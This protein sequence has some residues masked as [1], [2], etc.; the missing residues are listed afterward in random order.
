MLLVLLL[1]GCLQIR[2]AWLEDGTPPDP[3]EEPDDPTPGQPDPGDD[4]DVQVVVTLPEGSWDMITDAAGSSV[5][6]RIEV[7]YRP[8]AEGMAAM[9]A[10]SGTFELLAGEEPDVDLPPGDY[11]LESRGYGGSGDW[12]LAY[13]AGSASIS[14]DNAEMN[15]DL[16]P[17]VSG[18]S[19]VPLL[20][21]A[22]A[23][24]GEQHTFR[25]QLWAAAGEFTVT[26]TDPDVEFSSQAS[27]VEVDGLFATVVAPQQGLLDLAAVYTGPSLL[28][29]EIMPDGQH[30]ASTQLV[31]QTHQESAEDW[32]PPVLSF[33]ELDPSSG[34]LS[35]HAR[36]N[37]GLVA[38]RVY[39][40]DEL[41]GSN[42]LTD[43]APEQLFFD[44]SDP[45]R[46]SVAWEPTGSSE[47]LRAEAVD[48]SGNVS[49]AFRALN[50]SAPEDED[51]LGDYITIRDARE[52]TAVGFPADTGYCP[53]NEMTTPGQGLQAVGAGLQAVGAIGGLLLAPTDAMLPTMQNTWS[54]ADGLWFADSGSFRAN[55]VVVVIVDDFGNSGSHDL[56]A[57]LFGSDLSAEML[58]GIAESGLLSHGALVTHHMLQLFEARGYT[59]DYEYLDSNHS[60]PTKV[61][62]NPYEPSRMVIRLVNTHG[63]DTDGIAAALRQS[64]GG[65]LPASPALGAPRV[66]VNMSFVML[67]CAVTDDLAASGIN[68]FEEY[69]E[70]LAV[71]NSVGLDQVESLV[72]RQ[73]TDDDLLNYL[74]CPFRDPADPLV[75]CAATNSFADRLV[76]VASAGNFGSDY[77]LL[78]AAAPTVIAVSA[79]DQYES[80]F[81]GRSNYSNPG[82]VMAPGTNVELHS[83]GGMTVSYSGTSFAAPVVTV[84]TALDMRRHVPSCSDAASDAAGLAIPELADINVGGVSYE[85]VKLNTEF[86]GG[87]SAV[88]VSDFCSAP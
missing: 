55:D 68:S 29:G 13:G 48:L 62:S 2:D 35:G 71:V 87:V 45:E 57:G 46:W 61:L 10:G 19:L 50:V 34:M 20:P 11:E 84:M 24:P 86:A 5:L 63:L 82:S 53:A 58:R 37:R 42:V 25:L 21:T 51:D 1:P 40:G 31:V 65:S 17:L 56:P 66:V 15:L 47:I 70:A 88:V 38:L 72:T 73:P 27:A 64:F 83:E 39:R 8:A 36:D 33:D 85:N 54:T 12:L 32:L 49:Q 41:L 59:F 9:E 18:A 60:I 7:S 74:N 79:Q 67:P 81:E 77:P 22:F 16:E 28:D 6:Q 76:H 52:G 23:R 30:Q 4:G 3:I 44:S 69:L 78:P 43:G 80:R 26:V 14:R 75:G